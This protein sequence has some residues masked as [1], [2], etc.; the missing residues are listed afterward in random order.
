MALTFAFQYDGHIYLWWERHT[1]FGTPRLSPVLQ[2]DNLCIVI[3]DPL[4]HLIL[5]D[6]KERITIKNV[7]S[8]KMARMLYEN[9][10]DIIKNSKIHSENTEDIELNI[11]VCNQKRIFELGNPWDVREVEYAF[12]SNVPWSSESAK[13]YYL[14]C[15]EVAEKYKKKFYP[16]K[17]LKRIFSRYAETLGKIKI[18]KL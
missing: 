7:H 1:R 17:I 3:K 2:L 9:I 5:S 6:E 13:A 11:I 4:Y 12:F 14:T 16:Q 10:Q 18:I 8:A 15:R